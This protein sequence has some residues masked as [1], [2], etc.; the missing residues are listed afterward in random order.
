MIGMTSWKTQY[1]N[2]ICG[3]CGKVT[4]VRYALDERG[5]VMYCI[6]EVEQYGFVRNVRLRR[7]RNDYR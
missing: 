4:A 1:N 6:Q 7:K 3:Y 2:G 5:N